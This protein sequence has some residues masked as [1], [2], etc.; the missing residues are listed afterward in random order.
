MYRMAFEL[1]YPKGKLDDAIVA[2]T[3]LSSSGSRT[4][5]AVIWQRTRPQVV[6]SYAKVRNVLRRP[7]PP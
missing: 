7:G 2:L 5:R 6:S 1:K 3:F 4:R